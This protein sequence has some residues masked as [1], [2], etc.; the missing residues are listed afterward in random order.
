MSSNFPYCVRVGGHELDLE[1]VV[2]AVSTALEYMEAID[3][4]N[5]AKNCSDVVMHSPLTK[6]LQSA[7]ATL[8]ALMAANIETASVGRQANTV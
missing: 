6:R 4:S 5:A 8:R 3:E 7:S 1:N 2:Y